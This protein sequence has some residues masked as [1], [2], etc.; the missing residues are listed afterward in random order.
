MLAN[1]SPADVMD[2]TYRMSES[3]C[4]DNLAEFC[5]TIVQ[6]YKEKYLCE[7]NQADMDRLLRKAE[8]ND[9]YPKWATLVQAIANHVDD[10]QRWFTLRQEAYRKDVKRAFDIL[11]A[12]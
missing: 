1:A 11:Q 8:D 6:L 7:P 9:I 3:T 5:Y 10:A 12:R 2:D 4:L